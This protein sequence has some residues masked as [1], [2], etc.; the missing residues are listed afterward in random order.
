[1]AQKKKKPKLYIGKNIRI[2]DPAF[3]KIKEFVDDNGLK[4]GKFVE[5]AA[6]EK[7]EKEKN[8]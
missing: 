1:M 8:N 6:L 4:L 3:D 2:S 7:L 5:I